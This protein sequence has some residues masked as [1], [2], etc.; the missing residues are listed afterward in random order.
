M[1]HF[2]CK[3]AKLIC[4]V[5]LAFFIGMG[6]LSAA[7]AQEKKNPQTAGVDNT[8]M[9]AYRAIAQHAYL[10]F[11]KGDVA[12]A[13][14]LAHSLERVWDKGE[15]YGGDT[16]LKKTHPDLFEQIDKAMDDFV[17]PL[18]EYKNKPPDPARI[19]AAFAA[20]MEKLKLAD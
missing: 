13:A 18:M 16:A 3:T 11:Q 10:E 14:Q 8:K 20:Y 2:S 1:R 17:Q 19:K 15:D 12:T 9:G 6:A 4:A 5:L 7:A